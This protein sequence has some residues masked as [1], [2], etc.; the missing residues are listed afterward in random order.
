MR[1]V[2]AGILFI[3]SVYTS[4]APT[5]DE[6]SGEPWNVQNYRPPHFSQPIYK[7]TILDHDNIEIMDGPIIL[8]NS[9]DG[10]YFVITSDNYEDYALNPLDTNSTDTK[11]IQL[12]LTTTEP[13]KREFDVIILEALDEDLV[14]ISRTTILIF[15][16]NNELDM[17]KMRFTIDDS[18]FIVLNYFYF[19][20]FLALLT[21]TGLL[22]L[23]IELHEVVK[24]IRIARQNSRFREN[25][26][27]QE[28][29]HM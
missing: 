18:E 20:W 8:E 12:E 25:V 13:V 23:I 6:D 11:Q 29:M 24:N 14:P 19:K 15:N 9:H 26:K 3:L 16:S 17:Y 2:V 22:I 10:M 5:S 21:I 4:A 7:A 1:G 27:Y 28:L